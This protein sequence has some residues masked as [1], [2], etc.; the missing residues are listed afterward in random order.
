MKTLPALPPAKKK[1]AGPKKIASLLKL[2][3][4]KLPILLPRL[5]RWWKKPRLR[6]PRRLRLLR[7][8]LLNLLPKPLL[9]LRLPP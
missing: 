2:L 6:L 3:K 7:L 9:R 1:S 8:P 5:S 4:R